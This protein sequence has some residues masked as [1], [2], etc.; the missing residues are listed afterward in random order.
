MIKEY[1]K[2]EG[3]S[4]LLAFGVV[5]VVTAICLAYIYFIGEPITTA[6]NK[7]NDGVKYINIGDYQTAK[8]F[9]EESNK[10]WW[11]TETDN[12]LQQIQSR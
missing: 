8:Q 5:L 9:F 10:L 12:Y 7:F 3:K 1:L 4:M 2:K 6:R 11:T